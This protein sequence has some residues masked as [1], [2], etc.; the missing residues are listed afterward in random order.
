MS[1]A[2]NTGKQKSFWTMTKKLLIIIVILGVASLSLVDEDLAKF[3]LSGQ[4]ATYGVDLVRHSAIVVFTI[5]LVV[6]LFLFLFK[7]GNVY[8]YLLGISLLVWLLAQR[9]YVI[10]QNRDKILVSG[11]AVFPVYSSSLSGKDTCSVRIDLFMAGEV[12]KGIKAAMQN[13]WG[14]SYY[15]PVL[16]KK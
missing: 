8:K 13:L 16:P 3:V 9:T 2:K 6:I 11:F 15:Q 4:S 12:E 1:E 7:K 5:S 10:V 14:S